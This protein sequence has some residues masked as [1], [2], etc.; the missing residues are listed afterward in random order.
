MK[1]M[2]L[3]VITFLFYGISYTTISAQN[4][5][6]ISTGQT[7][8][9]GTNWSITGN[10]L[11]VTGTANIRASVIV[12]ALA[13]GNLTLVGN[14]S[15]FSV[16]VS[17]AITATGNN[18]LTVGSATNTGTITFNAVTSFAGPITVNGGNITVSQNI[19]CTGSGSGLTLRASGFN[20]IN[21]KTLQTNNGN[22]ILWSDTDNSQLAAGATSDEIRLSAA[23]TLN[24]QGGK[25]VLA[26][27]LDDGANGGT[28]SDGI[29]DNYAYRGTGANVGGVNLGPAEG[30]GTVVSLLS[31]GGDILI[32]GQ[33]ASSATNPRAGVVSQTKLAINSGVGRINVLGISSVDDSGTDLG[34]FTEL[35][36]TALNIA[37]SSDYPGSG[38]AIRMAGA[39]ASYGL[40]IGY[41]SDAT[42]SNL[43]IQSTSSTGG[44]ILLEGTSSSNFKAIYLLPSGSSQ[45]LSGTGDIILTAAP[46]G[47]VTTANGYVEPSS[48]LQQFGS[49]ANSTPI[50]GITP[51]VTS[52]NANVICRGNSIFFLNTGSVNF[53]TT[54]SCTF[55]PQDGVNSFSS[56]LR[57][58][59]MDFSTVSSLTMGKPTNTSLVYI[60]NLVNVAGPIT[61][62][63]GS[64]TLGASLSSSTGDDIIIY[65]NAKPTVATAQTITT[66]GTF[67]FMP[68]AASF[69]AA[70]TYPFT[71]LT[72][73]NITRFDL[74]KTGNTANITF[75]AATTIAG[76]I[77]AYG[78][79]IAVNGN[80]TSSNGSTISL[81]GNALTFGTSKT[82]TSS[83]GQ[84]IISPQNT[85]TT[86]GIAGASGTLQLPASCFSS[87]FVDGFSN[88]QIGSNS[89]TGA[90]STNA[91][92]LRD[93]MTFLTAGSL[94]LGGKP[95]LGT[96]SVT[97]GSAI[98]SFSG[99]PT[100]YFQTNGTGE[101]IRNVSHASTLQFPI[102][103]SSYNPVSIK[104]N[105]G[106]ADDFSV[107]VLDVIENNPNLSAIK[108]VNR[109]WEI[110]KTNNNAGAGI[111]F[112]FN[113]NAGEIVNGPLSNP[114][115]NH[116]GSYWET[117]IGSGTA[118]AGSPI[119]SLTHTGYTGTFSPFAIGNGE[120]ALPI[121]I[122]SLTANCNSNETKI[123]WQ[124]ASEHNSSHFVVER[125][126]DGIE[127][128]KLGEV[129]A[130]G[131]STS[132]L[133]YS[134][135][136]V[137]L[138]ARALSYY[139][140]LQV[141]FDGVSEKYGPVS[142]N[143]EVI[144]PFELEI[145]PNPNT[146]NF[147]L[148]VAT[149]RSQE[150][151]VRIYHTDGKEVANEIISAT[152]GPSLHY[153]NM[154]Y[155]AAGIY[156]LCVQHEGGI[157]SRKIVIL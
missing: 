86:I 125:S 157:I 122:L 124:T 51:A 85:S 151:D 99:M 7:T 70:I 20:Y 140:L 92:T 2:I 108:H 114:I 81:F 21:G 80:I 42:T 112:T 89:Q 98:S 23:T 126:V 68:Q 156:T 12:N 43:L 141:D 91:F 115:L 47:P 61:I 104:N 142:N 60:D 63:G 139:R 17:E 83:N 130:A 133:N 54:G 101:V 76:P 36:A 143:C 40:T 136:D 97:L 119:L 113:W 132:I 117:A 19:S 52:S 90:I 74:G 49:R 146:G 95:I 94:T 35:N 107:R 134:F 30:A 62:Y 3:L 96:N 129:A 72:V 105:S 87:N 127:W 154:E 138:L 32:R 13:N 65:S 100:H 116:Y 153:L 24:S 22:I 137:S 55:L 64:I 75:G 71:N 16:T 73:A 67:K 38:P 149:K 29:P 150:M 53:A 37:I 120:S 31:G 152:E 135:I 144:K 4:L 8:S 118:G 123:E 39:G 15:T 109:T 111:D 28:A 121:E 10:T 9:P 41:S 84:L 45:L 88:I 147:T 106:S 46:V 27:G 48:L 57:T 78:G 33:S 131:N 66:S 155:L 18:T 34:G 26:G 56:L 14:T 128:E 25:I 11:T 59:I 103:N 82:V 93:N 5:N 110:G 44:G 145:A 1:R 77:T 50:L 6:I 102:G 69:S 79:T 148:K 58:S